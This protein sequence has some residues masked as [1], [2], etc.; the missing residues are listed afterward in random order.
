MSATP[1]LHIRVKEWFVDLFTEYPFTVAGVGLFVAGFVLWFF[2]HTPSALIGLLVVGMLLGV[3]L[4]FVLLIK[5]L[6]EWE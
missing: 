4:F 2:L 3:I 6:E 5:I 1:P